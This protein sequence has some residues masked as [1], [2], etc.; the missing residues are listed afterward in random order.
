MNRIF[1][2]AGV[3]GTLVAGC[4]SSSSTSSSSGSQTQTSRPSEQFQSSASKN[5]A[6][7]T[8]PF[9]EQAPASQAKPSTSKKG[10]GDTHRNATAF[11]SVGSGMTVS[12]IGGGGA[13]DSRSGSNCT[14]A[15]SNDTFTTHGDNERHDFG[16]NSKGGGVC[17]VEPSW[18][19][20][21]VS[22][23]DA[24]GKEVGHGETLWLGQPSAV[25]PYYAA[26]FQTRKD[27]V[28][29]PWIGLNCV[30]THPSWP[31]GT[32]VKISRK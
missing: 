30:E 6:V 15:E 9:S 13:D 3:I 4:G 18:S 16:F 12:I 7:H 27:E 11:V 14:N 32:E 29:K 26:C 17:A 25:Y 10:V 31:K 2:A 23:K 5:A 22:V 24:G 28:P 20:F 19:Y 21:K 1:I 8:G